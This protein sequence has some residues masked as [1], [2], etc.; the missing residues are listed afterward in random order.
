MFK[1]SLSVAILI[2]VLHR[3]LG[4]LGEGGDGTPPADRG[5]LVALLEGFVRVPRFDMNVMF[6]AGK[7]KNGARTP[8][9]SRSQQQLGS[10]I[11]AGRPAAKASVA[12]WPNRM[13]LRVKLD[14]LI[15]AIQSASHARTTQEDGAN[16]RVCVSCLRASRPPPARFAC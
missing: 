4:A 9:S 7:D 13:N 5:F 8:R 11:D 2:K 12:A 14:Q 6:L 3:A 16:C 1:D 10:C 15:P